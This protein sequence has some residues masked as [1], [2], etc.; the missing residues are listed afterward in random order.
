MIGKLDQTLRF[1]ASALAVRAERQQ[2]LASNIANADTPG[3]QSK[4]IE[5]AG[6][7][8]EALG[9]SRVQSAQLVRT[10]TRHILPPPDSMPSSHVIYRTARQPSADGNTV[11]LDHERAQFATN[12]VHYEA[13]LTF[14]TMQ[15]KSLMSAIQ[16]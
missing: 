11:D 14:L 13:N 1:H 7:L 16:G 3:F 4:D 12:A 8:K 15:I 5:F 10:S 9:A 2:M 6:A